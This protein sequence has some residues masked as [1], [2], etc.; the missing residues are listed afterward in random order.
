M[1]DL[2]R[3]RL[4]DGFYCEDLLKRRLKRKD[5]ASSD[6][7]IRQIYVGVAKLFSQGLGVPGLK[8]EIGR[9]LNMDYLEKELKRFFEGTGLSRDGMEVSELKKKMTELWGASNLFSAVCASL[10]CAC[11]CADQ[12]KKEMKK[13]KYNIQ[14]YKAAV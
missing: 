4:H 11:L 7:F 6:F 1:E 8:K 13:Y 2:E 10:C 12:A 5:L 3:R 14:Q 9:W